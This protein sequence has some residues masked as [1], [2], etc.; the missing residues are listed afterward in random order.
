MRQV[1]IF[2]ERIKD[3][4]NPAI[5]VDPAH[6]QSFSI[7]DYSVSTGLL[8]TIDTSFDGIQP[9]QRDQVLIR[10]KAFSCNYRDKG[11]LLKAK[12][13]LDNLAL[14]D[15]LKFYTLGSEF[16]G[17]VVAVGEDV[18]T[19][20]IGDRVIGNGNYPTSDY[21]GVN[22]GLPTNHGS[23]E[24]ETFHFS[25]LVKVPEMMS[26][27]VAASFPIGGQTTYSMIRRLQLKPGEKVLVTA[28][29]SN[30]SLFAINALRKEPVEVYAVTTR[31]DFVDQ[32][33]EMG[34]NRV[35]VIPRGLKTL[36][37][38]DEVRHFVQ[39]YGLFDAVIDPFFDV[40]L[41]QV[42]GAM[43]LHGRYIT[44]GMYDQPY[45][46]ESKELERLPSHFNQI[47][48]VVMLKNIQLI[49][50]CI[51]HTE[52]LERA[53]ADYA[54]GKLEVTIDSVY[55]HHDVAAFFDRSFNAK[56]RFGKVIYKYG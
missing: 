34:A 7:N 37:E 17:E 28:A 31:D 50:N 44:C 25:K 39:M 45:V 55:Q 30:T 32:L 29:T 53:V 40:Y 56:D 46:G 12:H 22:P 26:D 15:Q 38:V 2:N 36:G 42:V 54:A 14:K 21:E 23:K 49:G 13:T 18:T 20:A 27:E 16:V 1:A 47:M 51:G 4:A 35:F 19:L 9:G 11:I 41:G 33:M 24:L 10:K 48:S 5:R 6:I 3:L 8:E 43:A 52:D